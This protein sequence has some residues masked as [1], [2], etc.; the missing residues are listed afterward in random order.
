MDL[1]LKHPNALRYFDRPLDVFWYNPH[2]DWPPYANPTLP[3]LS[4]DDYDGL[5]PESIVLPLPEL[6]MVYTVGVHYWSDH[7]FGEAN[8]QVQIFIFGE[9]VYES[10]IVEMVRGDLWEVARLHWPSGE[11][12]LFGEDDD[13][14]IH[15]DFPIPCDVISCGK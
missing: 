7:E 6:D 10:Q 1:H 12:E 5:G 11:V 13:P 15:M 14:V 3:V 8:A 9:R 2:P 4:L